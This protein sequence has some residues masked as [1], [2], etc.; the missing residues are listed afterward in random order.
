MI[1]I[2]YPYLK[3]KNSTA[4]P[5]LSDIPIGGNDGKNDNEQA[6]TTFDP[7]YIIIIALGLLL[8]CFTLALVWYCRRSHRIRRD[9][10]LKFSETQAEVQ[11]LKMQVLSSS[12]HADINNNGSTQS[13]IAKQPGSPSSRR[14]ADSSSDDDT[15]GEGE[16]EGDPNNTNGYDMVA[17]HGHEVEEVEMGTIA[18]EKLKLNEQQTST[19]VYVIKDDDEFDEEDEDEDNLVNVGY[20]D[21]GNDNAAGNDDTYYEETV[22][23]TNTM[24]KE[25]SES[26]DDDDEDETKGVEFDMTLTMTNDKSNQRGSGRL[27]MPQKSTQVSLDLSGLHV[28]PI[29]SPASPWVNMLILYR[30]YIR[31]KFDYILHIKACKKYVNVFLI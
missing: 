15:G 1:Q 31:K 26:D 28:R 10:N 4:T 24:I 25:S 13:N 21:V 22:E 19:R 5:T 7:L 2:V 20:D 8:C 14:T 9:M 11:N 23:E 3:N 29:T 18:S 17:T 27:H 6:S 12:K 30:K 16:S